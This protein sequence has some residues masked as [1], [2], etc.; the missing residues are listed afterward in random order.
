MNPEVRV[1]FLALLGG[2]AC[3][4]P[5][6]NLPFLQEALVPLSGDWSSGTTKLSTR[7]LMAAR[8]VLRD[9]A[10]YHFYYEDGFYTYL[11]S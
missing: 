8:L 7:E 6:S 5:V 11:D 9:W 10:S 3:T 4:L 2:L 1:I